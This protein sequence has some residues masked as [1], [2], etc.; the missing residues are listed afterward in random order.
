VYF[1]VIIW[2]DIGYDMHIRLCCRE[3]AGLLV[4]IRVG[5]DEDGI[6]EWVFF[7]GCSSHMD[8]L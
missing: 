3:W 8:G 1:I 5:F 2:W 7:G 4:P 6:G